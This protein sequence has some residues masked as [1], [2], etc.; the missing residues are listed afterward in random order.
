MDQSNIK[1]PIYLDN[2]AT[3]PVD[4]RVLDAMLPYFTETFGNPHS[5][6][7]EFGWIA[8]AAVEGARQQIAE[9]IGARPSEI[10]FTSGATESNNLALKGVLRANRGRR[11]R[12]VTVATEHKCVLESAREL[13]HEGFNTTYLAV[14]RNGLVDLDRLAD[15]VDEDTALVSIMAV[16]NE[17][18]VIQPLQEIGAICGRAGALLHTD[19]A[20]AVG[21]IPLDVRAMNIA[22]MSLTAHK[23]YG[24]KGIGALYVREKP[25]VELVALFSGGGQERGLRAGT[26]APALCVALGTACEVAGKEMADE[27]ARLRQLRDRLHVGI[28]NGLAGVTLNGDPDRRVAGNLNLSFAGVDGETLIMGIKELAISSGSACTSTSI[29]PSHVLRALGL[30][31]DTVLATIRFGLGR[32]TTEAEIDYAVATVVDRVARLRQNPARAQRSR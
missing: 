5:I 12:L 13:A 2:Q 9:L 20:Q 16:N 25:S 8:E 3:T 1:L 31:D 24:P 4:P 18:G 11:R 14:Q 15:A 19:A 10:I 6:S 22:L 30:D 29:E 32:F 26:L 23:F 21:K 28:G 27:A 7:H 17:I